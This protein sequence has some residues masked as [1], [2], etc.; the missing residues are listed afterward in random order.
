M[1]EY[2]RELRA[3]LGKG[4]IEDAYSAM[5]ATLTAIQAGQAVGDTDAFLADVAAKLPGHLDAE[6]VVGGVFAVLIPRI[7]RGEIE[8]FTAE[9]ADDLIELGLQASRPK[10]QGGVL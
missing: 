3:V 7:S 2:L 6:E 10:T 1:L 4:G 5:H 9:M 8:D